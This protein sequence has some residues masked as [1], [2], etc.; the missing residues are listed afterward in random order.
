MAYRRFLSV[1]R[2]DLLLLPI[3]TPPNALAD[4]TGMIKQKD[5]VITGLIMG[6]VGLILGY[7]LL[8]LCGSKGLI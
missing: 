3:S 1:L 4:A 8:I 7:S 6:I 2:S 5:M